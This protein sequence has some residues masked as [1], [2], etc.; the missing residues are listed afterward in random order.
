M[1][2]AGPDGQCQWVHREAG[3]AHALLRT[4]GVVPPTPQPLSFDGVTRAVVDARLDRRAE[5]AAALAV[6]GRRVRDDASDEQLVLHAWHAWAARCVEH[7]HGDFSL[8]IWD[9]LHRRLF[10]ARDRL[11]IR[12]LYWA[13]LPG[14]VIVG[15]VQ[16]SL[17]L[18][19]DCSS[20]LNQQAAADF[21]LEG[22]LRDPHATFLADIRRLPPAHCLTLDGQL[23]LSCYWTLHE[24]APLRYRRGEDY[25]HHFR[26]LLEAAV[27]DR[28][29]RGPVSVLMSG[30]LDSTSVA[31]IARRVAGAQGR[32]E[33]HTVI[34]RGLRPDAEERFALSAAAH[35]GIPVHF[36][37][38]DEYR[39]CESGGSICEPACDA[40][41]QISNDLLRRASRRTRVALSGDGGDVIFLYP[42]G[43]HLR[44]LLARKRYAAAARDLAHYVR[45]FGG[46]PRPLLP[47]LS[48]WLGLGP[49][50]PDLRQWR[51]TDL[52]QR[53]DGRA[54][55]E[56]WCRAQAAGALLDPFWPAVFEQE[57]PGYTGVPVE[58]RYPLLD[59]RVVE[60]VLA[61]PAV[62]WMLNK[63]LLRRAM[64]GLLP[65]C[66]RLRPKTPAGDLIRPRL[67][68]GDMD[69]A[70]ELQ[71]QQIHTIIDARRVGPPRPDQH[72]VV[73]DLA[74]RTVLL[75]RWLAQRQPRPAPEMG[76]FCHA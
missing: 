25:V 74:L 38:A 48:R 10:A 65:R 2:C 22:C 67:L 70:G 24:P 13:K 37:C 53:A 73:R 57:H 63:H 14:C 45:A 18:H 69:G 17:A 34:H 35:L 21:L 31:A 56:D 20:R 39:L 40:L 6:A 49:T 55:A 8:I 16:Q 12:P 61:I 9:S 19:P 76:V 59:L 62:P 60:F 71:S 23:R 68:R 51:R 29:P 33:A 43:A 41:G 64:R 46:L 1:S 4:D 52:P 47:R 54:V 50:S 42:L 66:V 26:H 28:L 32:L 7:L 3:L 15:N 44:R 30:G 72:P 5:L 75:D 36:L 11:G 27:A 58:V